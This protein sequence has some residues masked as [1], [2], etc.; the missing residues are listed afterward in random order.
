MP[1]LFLGVPAQTPEIRNLYMQLK[2]N[3]TFPRWTPFG[4][5]HATLLF[6]GEVPPENTRKL[7]QIFTECSFEPF[8]LSFSR[9]LYAP[10]KRPRM[11][12]LQAE[13]HPEFVR[14]QQFFYKKFSR[15]FPTIQKPKPKIHIT[16]ARFSLK[17]KALPELPEFSGLKLPAASLVFYQS[18]LTP[19]G[20][21]YTT[22]AELRA[23]A[24]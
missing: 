4:N 23:K 2:K 20:A 13:D 5:L 11:I 16:L 8:L 22:L 12:W 19:Q 15:I 7:L 18:E 21:K 9:L 6:I 17:Q 24:K 14:L 10:R 3:R 1:R